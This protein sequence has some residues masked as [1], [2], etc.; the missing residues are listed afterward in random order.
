M[1]AD[2]AAGVAQDVAG[3]GNAA[4]EQF[5]RTYDSE[6]PAVAMSSTAPDP[7]NASPIPVTVEF[8]EA[9]TGFEASDIGTSNGA[10]AN[11][12]GTGNTYG[13]DLV[14]TGDGL[15]TADI[16]AGAAQDAAGN[17]SKAAGQFSRTYDAA[18]PSVTVEQADG[19]TDPTNV[20]PIIFVVQF[21]KEVT[22]FGVSDVEI[23]GTA[24]GVEF[25]MLG[26]G[27]LYGIWVTEVQG[28]GTVVVT[29]PAGVAFDG[30]GNA[31]TA[32]TS[33]DNAVTYDT[34]A[35]TWY[36]DASYGGIQEGSR[37]RPFSTIVQATEATLGGRG[38]TIIVLPGAYG[39]SV[40]LKPNTELVGER[41]AHHTILGWTKA[42]GDVVTLDEGC[43][44]RGFTVGGGETAVH[45]SAGA[46][47]TNCVLCESDTGLHAEA[48]ARMKLANNT[49]YGNTAYGLYGEPTAVFLA[50]INNVLAFNGT[51][52]SSDGGLQLL[53]GYNDFWQN[54]VDYDGPSPNATDLAVDPL[55]VD[56]ES[57]NFHLRLASECRDAG[58]PAAAFN[59]VDGTRNDLG[60]DGG[61]HGVQDELAPT[62]VITTTPEPAVGDAPLQVEF[63]GQ[64][65]DDEWRIAAY[66]WDFDASDGLQE[67]DRGP[68]VQ[69]EF[70]EPGAYVVSL[71]VTDNSGFVSLTTVDVLVSGP[72]DVAASAAP[73]AGPVPLEVQ[74]S[75]SGSDWRGDPLSFAWDFD[76]DGMADNLRQNAAYTY[77]EGTALGSHRATLT[78][79][80][81]GERQSLAFA[82]LTV[83]QYD[84]RAAQ[85]I[86][87]NAGG[88]LV[89]DTGKNALDGATLTIPAGAV[90]APCVATIGYVPDPPA[91]PESGHFLIAVELG[92][93]GIVFAQPVVVALPA[94]ESKLNPDA[95]EVD[96]F[97]AATGTWHTVA[98]PGDLTIADGFVTFET[99]HFCVFAL[100][101]TEAADVN[102]DGLVNAVD[103]QLVINAALGVDTGFNCDVNGDGATNAIDVQLVINAALGIV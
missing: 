92:P 103:V 33:E 35:R 26:T 87:R 64:L 43:T 24:T 77:P 71:T 82:Y 50:L 81:D 75:G 98:G 74:F 2:I 16:A 8:A 9:V 22:G 86:D 13:F 61:P 102:G 62:V 84:V 5:S 34:T 49:I 52:V 99:P 17:G 18:K 67:D 42:E 29:V 38:D 63:D 14:P 57:L 27:S 101:Q 48:S 36:V 68:V 69:R 65:S 60:A 76:A 45:A 19:Q 6:G 72:P 83:T 56:P 37:E 41:G 95:L 85:L 80:D 55:F 90:S 66:R 32:S 79:T 93:E 11:F 30:A 78:G 59:D 3:N 94:P 58:V 15:V 20:T 28:N 91:H 10:V 73:I 88:V 31:N 54:G 7:T 40:E 47:V 96:Y 89:V 44:L 97:D 23:G 53:A 46:T 100:R 1:T 4:A 70:E 25:G 12:S 39:E 21:S 51:A